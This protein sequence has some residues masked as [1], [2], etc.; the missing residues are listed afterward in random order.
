MFRFDD[1][2]EYVGSY[3]CSGAYDTDSFIASEMCCA[4]GGGIS[5]GGGNDDDSDPYEQ[6]LETAFQIT[7]AMII[8]LVVLTHQHLIMTKQQM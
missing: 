6:S 3:G 1:E 4:C 2:N 5:S 8:H 7:D